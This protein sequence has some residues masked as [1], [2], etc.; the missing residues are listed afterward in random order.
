MDCPTC[1]ATGRVVRK[2]PV[3][4]KPLP[5]NDVCHHCGGS[6]TILPTTS[7]GYIVRPRM[8]NAMNENDTFS[9][10]R[11]AIEFLHP[12]VSILDHG[13]KSWKEYLQLTKDSL[14]LLFVDQAQSGVAKEIDREDK[15][16]TLDKI[17]MHLYKYLLS[18]SV[19]IIYKFRFPSESI[20]PISVTL[21]STF[22]VKNESEIIND[23]STLRQQNA[24]D[25]IV[26]EVMR[27][28]ISKRYGNDPMKMKI[29]DTLI[30]IDPLYTKTDAQKAQLRASEA[31]NEHTYLFSVFAYPVVNSYSMDTPNFQDMTIDSITKAVIPLI[32]DRIS[33][34]A[35]AGQP[36][37]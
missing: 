37:Q 15:L 20:P 5:G 12:D 33:L 19:A 4:G 23:L 31:I 11:K 16:A 13:A 32:E 3:T 29:F 10:G 7:Y 21:P 1:N 35:N 27:E 9:S 36:R 22:V 34:E 30:S 24:P 6:K 28:M 26:G 25:F 17:G 8:K 14:N 18:E 2:S